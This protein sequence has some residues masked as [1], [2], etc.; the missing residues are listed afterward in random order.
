MGIALASVSMVVRRSW[1]LVRR[2]LRPER[3]TV[4]YP[5]PMSPP[6]QCG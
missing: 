2:V 6:I 1:G 3:R 5:Q 4:V